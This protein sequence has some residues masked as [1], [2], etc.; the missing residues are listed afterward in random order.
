MYSK[1]HIPEDMWGTEY[2]GMMHVTDWLPTIAA[3]AGIDLVGG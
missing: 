2:E 1:S 3:A